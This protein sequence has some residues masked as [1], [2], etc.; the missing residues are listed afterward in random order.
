MEIFKNIEQ[1]SEEWLKA[2][3][4]VITWTKLKNICW[5]SKTQ[6]TAMYE[7][8]AEEF[9]PLEENFSSQA[10]QRWKE[11]ESI[12]KAKYIDKTWEKV[13]EIW[14]IKKNDY[15]WLS[16]DGVIFD[17]NEK[18]KKAIE[19]KCPWAKNFT[20]CIL[21]NKIPEEYKYQVIMYFLVISDLEELDFILYNPDFYI[22]EKRLF[23]INIKRQDLEKD[24]YKAESQIEIFRQKWLEKIKKLLPKK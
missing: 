16:P 10:M 6:E 11:L 18:I 22:K 21:E 14:F 12:A 3:A 9:A 2:R 23:V 19:I 8:I 13:E 24:I 1:G 20:K 15:V 4:W 5:S 7:L 17:E